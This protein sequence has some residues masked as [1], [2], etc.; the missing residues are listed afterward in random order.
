MLLQTA[1][2]QT[3]LNMINPQSIFTIICEIFLLYLAYDRFKNKIENVVD[4]H[5]KRILMLED[6]KNKI[7]ELQTDSKL[8]QKDLDALKEDFI[9]QNKMLEKLED[10]NSKIKEDIHKIKGSMLSIELY[11]KQII[12]KDK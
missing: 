4:D 1:I 12:E 11:F 7:V 9:T 3:L 6:S 10:S 8:M 2:G 5:A